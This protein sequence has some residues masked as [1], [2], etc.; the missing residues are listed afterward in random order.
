MIILSLSHMCM[1]VLLLGAQVIDSKMGARWMGEAI[2]APLSSLLDFNLYPLSQ[3]CFPCLLQL[4]TELFIG[5][6]RSKGEEWYNINPLPRINKQRAWALNEGC[7][8]EEYMY[9]F[10]LSH[11]GMAVLLLGGQEIYPKMGAE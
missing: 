10:S 6:R 7:C 1:A 2:F 9:S 8:V 3:I 11:M 4:V 5:P